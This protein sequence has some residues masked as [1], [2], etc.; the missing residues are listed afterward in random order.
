MGVTI[1]I[2]IICSI[3]FFINGVKAHQYYSEEISDYPDK[4]DWIIIVIISFFY[5][6]YIIVGYLLDLKNKYKNP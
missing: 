3:Y 2:S 5:I 4:A 1:I 6:P